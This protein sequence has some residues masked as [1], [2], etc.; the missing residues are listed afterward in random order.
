MKKGTNTVGLALLEQAQRLNIE[1]KQA[2][3]RREY[4]K[5]TQIQDRVE[6]YTRV[7]EKLWFGR[8]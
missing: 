2:I 7:V 1:A 4:D 6:R 3:N 5:S 8:K